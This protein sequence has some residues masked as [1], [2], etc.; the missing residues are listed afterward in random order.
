MKGI[1]KK[2]TL[3]NFFG[4]EIQTCVRELFHDYINPL[5][6]VRAQALDT[7]SISAKNKIEN[8]SNLFA[9]PGELQ[10]KTYS[11]LNS[12]SMLSFKRTCKSAYFLHKNFQSKQNIL[13]VIGDDIKI[14]RTRGMFEFDLGI[15]LKDKV[16]KK[17]IKSS[18]YIQ[19]SLVKA[20]YSL[21][22]ALEYAQGIV[23]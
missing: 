2:E 5:P 9:I 4:S 10:Y 13:Y 16:S 8:N 3:P 20:F 23:A 21:Y 22:H 7:V 11:Y 12:E 1:N 18:L 19:N 14:T 15:A 6:E 17:E